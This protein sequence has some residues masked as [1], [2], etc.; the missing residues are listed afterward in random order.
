MYFIYAL[1]PNVW[2]D[3]VG[4]LPSSIDVNNLI[5][6]VLINVTNTVAK[7]CMPIV[8]EKMSIVKPITNDRIR[9]CH[10]GILYGSDKINKIYK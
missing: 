4:L 8:F 9:V 10:L 1:T 7:A 5:I 2:K 3:G 6:P